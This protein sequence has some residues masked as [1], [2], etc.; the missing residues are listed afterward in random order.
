MYSDAIRFEPKFMLAYFNRANAKVN[1]IDFI[2]SIDQ[3]DEV[4]R[5]DNNTKRSNKQRE[6]KNE[7][8]DFTD[9]LEDYN[10]AIILNDDFPYTYYNRANIYCRLTKFD[11]AIEDYTKA[12]E[13]YEFF[14]DAYFNRGLTYLY[15]NDEENGCKDISKAGEL[16]VSEAYKVIKRYCNK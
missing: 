7:I 9:A 11:E 10:R 8:F 13:V 4:I 1:M 6:N 3:F 5:I 16:G 2:S 12:I 15:L 14:G